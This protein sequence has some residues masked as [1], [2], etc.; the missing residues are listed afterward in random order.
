MQKKNANPRHCLINFGMRPLPEDSDARSS[1]RAT[2][3]A[4]LC[5]ISQ[6]CLVTLP[7]VVF[8]FGGHSLLQWGKWG[9][10]NTH[11]LL[12]NSQLVSGQVGTCTQILLLQSP[13]FFYCIMMVKSEVKVL[14]TQLCLT[15]CNP[16]D[17][18]LPGFSVRGDF[19]DKNIGMDSHSLL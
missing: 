2:Y 14:V 16:M 3:W 13:Y 18:S 17:Y 19:P 11:N 9:V 1:K 5:V 10:E 8:F 12:K 7:Q 6:Q 4:Q 15:L